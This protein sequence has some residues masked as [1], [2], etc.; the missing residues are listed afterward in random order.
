MF[1]NILRNKDDSLKKCAD[2]CDIFPYCF[3]FSIK[4]HDGLCTLHW[5]RKRANLLN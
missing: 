2:E 3:S 5:T 1:T 4:E